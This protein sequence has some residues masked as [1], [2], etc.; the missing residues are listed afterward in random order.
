M[1]RL[2]AV[3]VTALAAL[4][5][6]PAQDGVQ[7]PMEA[8]ANAVQAIEQA[9][10]NGDRAAIA[11]PL[12][13][14]ERTRELL[15]RHRAADWPHERAEPWLERVSQAV[16]RLREPEPTAAR[17]AYD[18]RELRASCTGCHLD[19]RKG[20]G[21]RGLFP[22]RGGAAF[23]RVELRARDGVRVDDASGVVVF[24]ERDEPAAAPLP[25]APAISQQGRRFRP[26]VLAVTVGT[27]VRF[28]NDDVVFHNVFSLSRGNAFDLQTYGKGVERTHVM[29]NAGLVKVHCNIHPDMVASVLVL[30]TERFAITDR[31]GFW[32]IPDV[33]A[34]TYTLRTWQ[35]LADGHG[36]PLN[37]AADAAVEVGL[38]VT[39]T[40]PRV[41]HADKFG[42]PCKTKY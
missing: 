5:P 16:A 40:K 12:D 34:G 36:Q 11:A 23:G 1:R 38:V 3:W 31:S 7:A 32:A 18:W 9:L 10:A 33:P 24:L 35:A 29:R 17:D 21:E 25:R 22:N 2:A 15:A 39:E 6:L 20:N 19:L 13:T 8:F 42:K 30:P 28:P 4:A 26:A 37:V 41:Q 27:T 14:L